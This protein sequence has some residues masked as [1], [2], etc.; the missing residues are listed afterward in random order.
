MDHEEVVKLAEQAFGGLS[1]DPTT[2]AQLIEAVR[3]Y[4]PPPPPPPAFPPSARLAAAEQPTRGSHVPRGRGAPGTV[5]L[6][7]GDSHNHTVWVQGASNM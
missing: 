6:E 2:A 3:L 7:V 1:S 5:L 4:P